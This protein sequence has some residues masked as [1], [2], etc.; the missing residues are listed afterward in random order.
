MSD[1]PY[2]LRCYAFAAGVLLLSSGPAI[3]QPAL[4]EGGEQVAGEAQVLERGPVHEAFAEPFAVAPAADEA[5]VLLVA[6]QPPEPIDELP[7]EVRPDGN[8]VQWV[9]GYWMWSVE[10]EDFIWISGI[11]RN[12]PPGREWVSGYW[13]EAGEGFRWISGFWREIDAGQPVFLPE[14]PAT[15]EVGPNQPAPTVEHF[16][17]PGCWTWQTTQYVWRPG[18]WYEGQNNWVWIPHRYVWTPRG[19]LF[20]RGYW[21]FPLVQRGLLYAPVYWTRPLVAWRHLRYSPRHVVNVNLLLGNLFVHPLHRHYYFGHYDRDF[22]H[23]Y[24]LTAWF[25]LHPHRHGG[26]RSYDPLLAYHHWQH[27]RRDPHWLENMRSDFNDRHDHGHGPGQ[28]R[29]E[30]RGEGVR[31]SR[32]GP[33]GMVRTVTEHVRDP[34]TPV[35]VTR[36]S[37]PEILEARQAARRRVAEKHLEGRQVVGGPIRTPYQGGENNGRRQ[38]T[39]R[40]K[41]MLPG[42]RAANQDG[43]QQVDPRTVNARQQLDARWQERQRRLREQSETDAAEARDRRATAER[44]VMNNDPRYQQYRER[45]EQ[46]RPQERGNA[47]PR[48]ETYRGNAPQ[49]RREAVPLGR[50]GGQDVQSQRSPSLRSYSPRRT[51]SQPTID[52][53]AVQQRTM[54]RPAPRSQQFSPQRGGG[55][56]TERGAPAARSRFRGNSG[57]GNSG[58]NG[59]GKS[60]RGR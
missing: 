20:V 10:R 60:R 37:N 8:N 27:H 58:G 35:K 36:L 48:V 50:F 5:E 45:I 52:R 15:L 16:W 11:W 46:F 39:T 14:P 49:V 30:Q 28:G 57:G 24:G 26:L 17:I 54:Q 22:R 44:R 59:R 43:E 55:G 3:G 23:R 41:A 21:D 19:F 56:Q 6:K 51:D 32:R 25:D 42:D 12:F 13:E 18:Y 29:G 9:P 31:I 53:G 7:P 33:D 40:A 1:F 2:S 47:T 34:D 38:A 4:P